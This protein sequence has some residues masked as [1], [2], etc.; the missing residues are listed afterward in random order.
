VRLLFA[1]SDVA[2]QQ[3][4]IEQGAASEAQQRQ[5]LLQALVGYV[6]SKRCRRR[7]LLEYFGQTYEQ[8]NCDGCDRCTQE[9][10]PEVEITAAARLLLT[11]VE[12]TGG[13][14]G[15]SHIIDVLRGSAAKKVIDKEHNRL[16][17]YNSG[18]DTTKK[19]WAFFVH[20]FVDQG[21]LVRDLKYG[22]LSLTAAGRAVLDGEAK[23]M[24]DRLPEE[25]RSSGRG[26]S[27]KDWD[28]GD[29]DAELFGVL[30]AKRT[31][32]A[33]EAN[34]PPYVIFGDRSLI[35]MAT[36]F[37]QSHASFGAIHGVG[38][39]KIKRFADEFIPLIVAHCEEND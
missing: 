28:A 32:L 18:R 5:T 27:S 3:R 9:Q 17:S 15:A 14:F 20:Q 35:E 24:G 31:E 4:F 19:E 16:S 36:H 12:Q 21:L 26:R 2:R 38:A 13:Y 10:L 29:Y 25:Q 22:S 1:P 6:S 23:V 39:T 7:S 11:C 8:D 33:N 37:P 30:R 34:V